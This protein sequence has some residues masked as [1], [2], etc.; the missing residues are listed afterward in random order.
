MLSAASYCP[1]ESAASPPL[2]T[3]AIYAALKKVIMIKTRKMRSMEVS[4]GKKNAKIT[5]A[6]NKRVISGTPL[7]N[8]MKT[9]QIHLIIGMSDCRPN[10]KATPRGIDKQTAIV[11]NKRL[12]I[13]PPISREGTTSSAK[14][15]SFKPAM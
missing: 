10:A 15:D 1:L 7:I 3:S 4:G 9:T 14:M 13:K 8:S 5:F 12:S 2:T 11:P 6:T